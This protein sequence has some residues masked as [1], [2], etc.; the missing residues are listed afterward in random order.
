[1]QI[2]TAM[3]IGIVPRGGPPFLVDGIPF[4]LMK[5]RGG[6]HFWLMKSRGFHFGGC[7]LMNCK[8]GPPFLGLYVD[9]F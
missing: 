2:D 3:S 6:L 5:S 4:W 1:M 9:E 8:G 7:M